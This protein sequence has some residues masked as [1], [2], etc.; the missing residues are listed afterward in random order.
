MARIGLVDKNLLTAWRPDAAMITNVPK[1]I[2]ILLSGVLFCGCSQTSNEMHILV[3]RP[4]APLT[5]D[6]LAV[7]VAKH[8]QADLNN[9]KIPDAEYNT[10]SGEHW[11]KAYGVFGASLIDAAK[12]SHLD[13]R[14]LSNCLMAVLVSPESKG[15]AL[16]PIAAT[17]YVQDGQKVWRIELKWET[18]S[19][20]TVG[21]PMG[22][23]R[24]HIFTQN[25]I[26]QV[27]FTTCR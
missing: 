15:L 20:L 2:A 5:A 26:K 14:S 10:L 1:V 4:V 9:L 23:T 13:S 18:P 22:H 25:E 21:Q 19:T 17:S 27:G 6:H 16:L 11:Q 8:T 7:T 12:K 24:T 3:V